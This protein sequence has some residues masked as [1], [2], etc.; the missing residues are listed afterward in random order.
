M[1][2][3][4]RRLLRP[5]VVDGAS[6][7]GRGQ[8]RL[9]MRDDLK[10]G[11]WWLHTLSRYYL[12]LDPWTVSC[13][14]QWLEVNDGSVTYAMTL[15]HLLPLKFA[16]LS[17]VV[18]TAQ[19]S[20]PYNARAEPFLS[21]MLENS[22]ETEEVLP[23]LTV[24]RTHQW[25]Y[26]A[27]RGGHMSYTKIEPRQD[28]KLVLDITIDYPGLGG[29]QQIY[30]FPDLDLLKRI[31]QIGSQGFPWSRYYF[32]KFGQVFGFWTHHEELEWPHRFPRE[33]ALQRFVD[34]RCLDLLG[35]LALLTDEAWLSATVTSVCSGHYADLEVCR[36]A[37]R[38]LI[39]CTS[40]AVTLV[41]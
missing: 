7:F 20:L 9:E 18:I 36:Q 10:Y 21:K 1:Q 17:G 19:K 16:G 38:Q 29:T 3:K 12:K 5:V 28:G 6:L 32:S 27:K 33:E 26:P 34:H 37:Y 39:P 2:I 13:R 25:I 8:T 41:G 40:E 15:E 24:A 22:I 31:A 30:E 11:S 35:A 23:I 14:G 4:K